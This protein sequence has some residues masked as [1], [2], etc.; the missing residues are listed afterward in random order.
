MT[1]SIG[2]VARTRA[3][4]EMMAGMSP[5]GSNKCPSRSAIESNA[6]RIPLNPELADTVMTDSIHFTSG[7]LP[8][9]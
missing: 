4:W 2:G 7:P 3:A 6:W 8:W 9:R 1:G 5:A